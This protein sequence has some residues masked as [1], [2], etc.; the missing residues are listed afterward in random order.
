MNSTHTVFRS[1]PNALPHVLLPDSG[2]ELIRRE[3]AL[4]FAEAGCRV[5]PIDPAHMF[6][7]GSPHFLPRLL[8]ETRGDGP[9]LLFSV[10]FQGLARMKETLGLLEEAGGRAAVWCVD[11]PWNLLAG[12]R[13]PRWKT[14]PLFVTDATFIPALLRHGAREAH[15]LPLAASAAIMAPDAR[16]AAAFPPPGDL[17]PLVF[18]GRSAFP[19]KERFFSGQEVPV[20]LLAQAR[21]MLLRGERPDLLWWEA[22]LGRG[23]ESLWPGKKARLPALGAE[24]SSLAWRALCLAKAARAGASLINTSAG[25]ENGQPGLD[26]FGDAGWQE[27]LP[28]ETRLR[29]PVDYYA[30]LPGIY[31]AARYSLCLTSL[32]LPEGLNQRH[33]DVWTAGGVCLTD[34]TPGLSLF[35]E[36]LVRP[37]AFSRPGDIAAMVAGLEADPAGRE[38][39]IAGWQSCIA[40]AHTYRHRVHAVLEYLE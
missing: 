34:A 35:P 25:R 5:T 17:A 10:N 31:A 9:P 32:Q 23:E 7:E 27:H 4:A 40:S 18:V 22:A 20:E 33:F 38:R 26:I 16:R 19:D 3:L 6:E 14:L 13:D 8:R 28:P 2:Q 39:L 36:E 29:P 15:H 24:E 37:V 11:N 21:A 30:R 1:R 12:V